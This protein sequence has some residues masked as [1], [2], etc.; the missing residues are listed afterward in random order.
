MLTYSDFSIQTVKS[1]CSEPHW[2]TCGHPSIGHQTL[3]IGPGSAWNHVT[4]AWSL[5]ALSGC[6]FKLPGL[7]KKKERFSAQL[8]DLLVVVTDTGTRC[9]VLCLG[10]K[11]W[12]IILVYLLHTRTLSGVA[13][14][15]MILL[16]YSDENLIYCWSNA[17]FIFGLISDSD[18]DSDSDLTVHDSESE[19]T[20]KIVEPKNCYGSQP[21]RGLHH[22]C[23]S[24]IPHI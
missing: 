8:S 15:H 22:P 24:G 19:H 1:T 12:H 21:H 2:A 11:L 4:Q 16:G 5:T 3:S 18:S 13:W 9:G 17:G 10:C 23:T 7:V 6:T 20:S 14:R